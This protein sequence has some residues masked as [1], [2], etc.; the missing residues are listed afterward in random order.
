M[1]GYGQGVCYM[2][3]LQRGLVITLACVVL[4]TTFELIRRRKL[5]EKYAILWLLTGIVLLICSLFPKIIYIVSD[6]LGLAHLT[7]MLLITV[8]FLLCIVLHFTTVMSSRTEKQTK[9]A[10]KIAILELR[11]NELEKNIQQSKNLKKNMTPEFPAAQENTE[12]KRIPAVSI[13]TKNMNTDV[14][15]DAIHS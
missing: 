9:I 12:K 13:S 7:T 14:V 15:G 5:W 10:Q 6:L 8:L 11:I 1:Q 2:T 4:F 3:T